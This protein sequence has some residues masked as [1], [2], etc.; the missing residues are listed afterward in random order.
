M[1]ALPEPPPGDDTTPPGQGLAVAAESLYLI[2]LLLLPGLGFLLL[3]G[4]ISAVAQCAAA[5]AGAFA[6]DGVGQSVGGRAADPG[7]SA[8]R[9][10]GRLSDR[11]DLGHR[12][13]LLHHRPRHAGA[14]RH[15]RSGARA[16][17]AAVPLSPGR[18]PAVM[19]PFQRRRVLV[20][21]QLLHPVRVRP[22][23]RSAALRSDP[24]PSDRVRPTVDAGPGRLSGR[25]HRHPA[26]GAQYSAAGDRADTGAGGDCARHRL[27]LGPAVLRLAVPALFGGGNHQPT[28]AQSQRQAEH[29]G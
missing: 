11:L 26:N 17:R 3:W 15:F 14:A 19:T 22:D 29:L 28:G 7:Q 12:H 1:P 8:D 18:N 21:G 20:S 2:N 27:A 6:A 10:S 9:R 5:G 24:R 13:S 25:P 16:G 23:L 4:C